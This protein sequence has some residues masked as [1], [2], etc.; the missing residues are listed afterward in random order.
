[1]YLSV[2]F[3]LLLIFCCCVLPTAAFSGFWF[4]GVFVSI[5]LT[6]CCRYQYIDVN[7]LI[8]STLCGV[9]GYLR[10][11][12]PQKV[13][14]SVEIKNEKQS[15]TSK[16]S[17][18]EKNTQGCSYLKSHVDLIYPLFCLMLFFFFLLR[19]FEYTYW[20]LVASWPWV[21]T[22]LDNGLS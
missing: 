4:T 12:T 9:S 7:T 13:S 10:V 22:L 18:S 8:F 3:L 15:L 11:F 5:L 21:A 14:C 6:W 19:Q 1:M 2:L 17:I 16:T 20:S